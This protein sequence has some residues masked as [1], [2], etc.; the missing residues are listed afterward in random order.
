MP[1]KLFRPDPQQAKL[2]GTRLENNV[3]RLFNQPLPL[4]L[5]E[6]HKKLNAI[7]PECVKASLNSLAKRGKITRYINQGRVHYRQAAA[8][9][10]EVDNV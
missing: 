10:A 1:E 3:M 5:V 7:S 2:P 9:R 8:A 6:I 4:T